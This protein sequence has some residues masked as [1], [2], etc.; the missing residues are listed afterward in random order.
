MAVTNGDFEGPG[1]GQDDGD[2]GDGEVDDEEDGSFSMVQRLIQQSEDVAREWDDCLGHLVK[3]GEVAGKMTRIMGEA[4]GE[5]IGED[6]RKE[7]LQREIYKLKKMVKFVEEVVEE[8]S[9]FEENDGTK[10]EKKRCNFYNRGYCKKGSLCPYRH[11][12]ENCDIILNCK[13]KECKK[14]HPYHCKYSE[15]PGGCRRG[16]SCAF[17]H[18]M[19]EERKDAKRVLS[20]DASVAELENSDKELVEAVTSEAVETEPVI[21]EAVES[22]TVRVEVEAAEKDNLTVEGIN[23]A[24]IA[25]PMDIILEEIENGDFSS[26]VLDR[27]L[28][29]FENKKREEEQGEVQQKKKKVSKRGKS[30]KQ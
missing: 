1:L 8:N 25:E 10:E 18:R 5:N 12:E 21:V 29:S 2:H 7:I 9:E 15:S 13:D 20:K 28:E 11:P 19:V 3:L 26:E 30:L 27:I 22:G 6:S 17:H 4:L 24:N 16:G 14:R 23:N